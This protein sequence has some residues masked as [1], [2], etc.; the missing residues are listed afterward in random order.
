MYHCPG[1]IVWINSLM[2]LL[3]PNFIDYLPYRCWSIERFCILGA[4]WFSN[5]RPSRL[6]FFHTYACIHYIHIF[7]CIWTS[8]RDPFHMCFFLY[9]FEFS[10]FFLRQCFI[11]WLPLISSLWG[12][13]VGA[14]SQLL[15]SLIFILFCYSC[16]WV[17]VL[18]E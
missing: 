15:V 11:G 2:L 4:Y 3:L 9:C 8:I 16:L 6:W 10:N 17:T 18:F 5:F 1:E 14:P 12:V 13:T 7:P